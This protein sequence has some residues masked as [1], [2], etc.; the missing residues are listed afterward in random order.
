MNV[1]RK[2]WSLFIVLSIPFSLCSCTRETKPEDTIYKLEKAFNTYNIEMMIE[3][4]EPSIQ[5][6]Y[7]GLMEVGG[8]LLGMD[9]KTII[10]GASGFANVYGD[11]FM[12]EDIPE[13]D[14]I[15][16]SMEEVD[17]NKD[18]ILAD[19]TIKYDYSKETLE[20]FT[21]IETEE[22]MYVYLICIDK[23]WYISGEEPIM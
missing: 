16:N 15:I 9:M 22:K 6:I 11:S 18:K 8:E 19:L 17:G 12:E 20:R 3:C 23:K 4:Y 14:I 2:L 10:Q 5:D 21:D 1:K 7:E 13:I